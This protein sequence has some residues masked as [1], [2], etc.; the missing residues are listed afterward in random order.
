MRKFDLFPKVSD[1]TFSVKTKT[2][3]VIS[4]CTFLFMVLIVFL[5]FATFSPSAG[6]HQNA[7]LADHLLNGSQ[8]S[9]AFFDINISYPC[10][11]LHVSVQ[12]LTGNHQLQSQQRVVMQQ[13]NKKLEPIGEFVGEKDMLRKC[14]NCYGGNQSACCNTCFDVIYGYKSM[15]RLV[16]KLSSIE[17]CVNDKRSIDNGESCRIKADITTEFTAG[18][19]SI[20]AGGST[21]TPVHF[22]NDLTYFGDGVNLSHW[23]KEFRF[24]E[25]NSN[26]VNPLS[27]ASYL[28]M[29]KGFYFFRY[30]SNLVPTFFVDENDG[31]RKETFQYSSSFLIK[32]ITKTVSKQIPRI[33][34]LFET[35]PISIE[36]T[37]KSKG[38]LQLITGVCAIIGGGFT[39]GGLLD[40]L[41]Y[42]IDRIKNKKN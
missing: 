32:Q 15:N 38:Y 4:L 2:G 23:I 1:D 31:K 27:G 19:I 14:G 30:M 24:G 21:K 25:E 36:V 33:S 6:T 39:L 34:F 42:R 9:S 17:Q 3:G 12:D 20:R 8:R 13:L 29:G 37:K 11:L 7:I 35:S 5:E 22:K 41:M 26:I 40:R 10:H 18:I 16:P 28:Q